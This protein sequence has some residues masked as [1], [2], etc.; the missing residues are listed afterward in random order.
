MEAPKYPFRIYFWMIP[1]E[2]TGKLRQT[3]YRMSEASALER[4]PGAVRVEAD[5]LEITRPTPDRGPM[6]S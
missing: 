2:R 5:S 3:R 1:D 4:Y 6:P